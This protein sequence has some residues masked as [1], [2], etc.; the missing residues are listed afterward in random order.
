[1]RRLL[2]FL[3][4]AAA[5]LA[6]LAMVGVLLM[7]LTSILGRLLDFHLPGTDAYAGYSMAAAGFLSLAHTLKKN[8]HIRV[9]LLMGR[10][11]GGARRGM[12]LWALSVAVLLAGLFA[13]FSVRLVWQSH[14]FNDMSTSNDA[15]PLW[16]PQIA[17]AV[18][19]VILL[20]AFIDEWVLELR[21]LRQHESG[22]EEALH[23]E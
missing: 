14:L 8:E 21:G 7:V 13:W 6:A 23:N 16:I 4:D 11:R 9:T 22:D 12:E 5:W 10:L 17:M 2:D 20:L 18:G 19:T 1:M 3:Y 15:T